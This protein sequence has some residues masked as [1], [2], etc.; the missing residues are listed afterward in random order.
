MINKMNPQVK[1]MWV[2]ALRSGDYNQQSDGQLVTESGFCCLGVLCD[3]YIHYGHNHNVDW[4]DDYTFEG[5]SEFPPES[6]V[7]WAGLPDNNPTLVYEGEDYDENGV[8][9][10]NDNG[11]SFN[12]I[13]DLIESQL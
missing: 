8:A 12:K 4:D 10:F 5:E 9:N 7:E 6:V 13:A 11:M 3:L 2:N 1:E